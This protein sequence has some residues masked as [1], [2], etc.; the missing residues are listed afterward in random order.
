M[1]GWPVNTAFAVSG[2][3]LKSSTHYIEA[4]LEHGVRVLIYA[5]EYDLVCNFVGNDRMTIGL[6]WHGQ[7]EF[8]A[9]PLRDW[10]VDGRSG[11]LVRSSAG[12]T[13]STIRDA[14]HQVRVFVFL[15]DDR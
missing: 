13:F 3:V 4:L 9:Q 14:G 5:G 7:Q 2:D 15:F 8:A 12:L 11:G 6:E 1:V 10:V